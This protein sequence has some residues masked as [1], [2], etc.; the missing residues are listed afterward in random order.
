[1]VGGGELQ[2]RLSVIRIG[3]PSPSSPKVPDGAA[4]PRACS[5]RICPRMLR[6]YQPLTSHQRAMKAPT[7]PLW[8]QEI[9]HDGFCII[10]RRVG[11]VGAAVN[12]TGLRLRGAIPLDRNL[13]RG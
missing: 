9:K 2:E 4:G 11:D 12:Q 8:V 13:S 7:G 10:A 6:L 5:R 3:G 1:M